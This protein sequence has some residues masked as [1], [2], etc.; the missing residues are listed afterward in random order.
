MT[1]ERAF[2]EI[3]LPL[4]AYQYVKLLTTDLGDQFTN[5]G[6]EPN[7]L[8]MVVNG[9][10]IGFENETAT[11]L[12]TENAQRH[13]IAVLQANLDGDQQRA[14]ELINVFHPQYGEIK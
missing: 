8:V 9:V 14:R 11:L 13:L 2:K 7:T 1:K 5:S 10:A 12:L 6:Q 3:K 4:G